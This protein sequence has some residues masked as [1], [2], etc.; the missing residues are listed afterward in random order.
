MTPDQHPALKRALNDA[1]GLFVRKV[2][3]VACGRGEH[4]YFKCAFLIRPF[5]LQLFR[6]YNNKENEH[7]DTLDLDEWVELLFGRKLSSTKDRE[8]A[9]VIVCYEREACVVHACLM[10]MPGIT[11][12]T[13]KRSVRAEHLKACTAIEG[14][15]HKARTAF[16]V[17]L[18]AEVTRLNEMA[19]DL[20]DR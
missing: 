8:R 14:N 2:R 16:F 20:R 11:H 1:H 3:A 12:I 19:V 6:K 7:K 18:D 5:H 15:V 9:A 17:A 13:I 4:D 10:V